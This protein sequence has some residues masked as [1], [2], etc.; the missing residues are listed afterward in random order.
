[1]HRPGRS[2][3]ISAWP[4]A[5]AFLVGLGLAWYLKWETRDLVW[6]LWLSSLLIGYTL[7]LIGAFA[8]AFAAGLSPVKRIV[9]FLG[10]LFLAAFFTLHFG[11]FHLGHSIFLQMF[12][13]IESGPTPQ[14][15]SWENYGVILGTYWP[16]V[17]AA[18]VSER[19]SF[20]EPW[21]TRGIGPYKNVIRLHLLIFFFAGTAAIRMDSFLV[22]AVVY[23]VY[24]FP[25]RLFFP[26]KKKGG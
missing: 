7:I 5:V 3:I 21:D 11:G 10:G 20:L 16:F 15:L 9:S 6:S 25:F 4:D 18:A 24:F 1:M 12:F 26:A 14:A 23:L 13:P 22:Y 17:I 2:E 19:R 8:P